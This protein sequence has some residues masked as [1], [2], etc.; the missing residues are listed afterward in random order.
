[1]SSLEEIIPWRTRRIIVFLALPKRSQVQCYGSND[2]A[3]DQNGSCCHFADDEVR[4]K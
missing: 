3:D 2:T 1:M 4:V